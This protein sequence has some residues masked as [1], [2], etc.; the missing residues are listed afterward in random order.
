MRRNGLVLAVCACASSQSNTDNDKCVF[1]IRMGGVCVR[2]GM[3]REGM[4]V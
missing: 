4:C 2:E 1:C 3:E